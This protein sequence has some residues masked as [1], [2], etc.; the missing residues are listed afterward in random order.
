[1]STQQT[2]FSGQA[3]TPKF[4]SDLAPQQRRDLEF[5]TRKQTHSA[6]Q[7][8]A[9]KCALVLISRKRDQARKD[10]CARPTPN[11]STVNKDTVFGRTGTPHLHPVTRQRLP[12]C[13]YFVTT[14]CLMFADDGCRV[15]LLLHSCSSCNNSQSCSC[16]VHPLATQIQPCPVDI[17][18]ISISF[19]AI[20]GLCMGACLSLVTSHILIHRRS[21]GAMALGISGI[22]CACMCTQVGTDS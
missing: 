4:A 12:S 11:F 15:V 8:W 5:S 20:A 16:T 19:S 18:F 6:W 14:K 13:R 10:R 22:S 9:L 17:Y 1:M 2:V 7:A 3:W 21:N